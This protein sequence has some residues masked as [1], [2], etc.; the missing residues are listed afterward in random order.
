MSLLCQSLRDPFTRRMTYGSSKKTKEFDLAHTYFEPHQQWID[1]LAKRFEVCQHLDRGHLAPF[2][3]IIQNLEQ[4]RGF[5][6]NHPCARL[7]YLKLLLLAFKIVTV[8]AR[9]VPLSP[10]SAAA[11]ATSSIQRW[12]KRCAISLLTI[13]RL[14]I[15]NLS[16]PLMYAFSTL[17][18]TRVKLE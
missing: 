17:Y 12:P 18:L 13:Y 7:C 5:T 16:V 1:F 15:L 14:F 6:S 9:V 10:H 3:R 4:R 2:I 11:N 8:S